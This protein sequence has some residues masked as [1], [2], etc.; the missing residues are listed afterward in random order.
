MEAF[1][2]RVLASIPPGTIEIRHCGVFNNLLTLNHNIHSSN[3]TTLYPHEEDWCWWMW[4]CL[5]ID[6]SLI[7]LLSEYFFTI[8]FISQNFFCY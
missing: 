4:L 8:C 3:L 6:L 5:C 1:S 7:I 2:S